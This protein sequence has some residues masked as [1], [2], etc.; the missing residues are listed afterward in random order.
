MSTPLT[1]DALSTL[2]DGLA[3][4]GYDRAA[5]AS[6]QALDLGGRWLQGGG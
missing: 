1:Q 6:Q 4:P 5:H 3:V 2:S